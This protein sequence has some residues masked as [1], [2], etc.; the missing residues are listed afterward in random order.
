VAI[1]RDVTEGA[2]VSIFAYLTR[3]VA[4]SKNTVQDG[5]LAMLEVACSRNQRQGR[6]EARDSKSEGKVSRFDVLV[7]SFEGSR[8]EV[9]MLVSKMLTHLK[10]RLDLLRQN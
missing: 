10:E 1:V 5:V 3:F 6:S 8:D 7:Q 4:I 2:S 9:P